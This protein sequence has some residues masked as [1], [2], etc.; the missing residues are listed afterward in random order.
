MTKEVE[1]QIITESGDIFHKQTNKKIL[2]VLE[3][4][5]MP[6]L[7]SYSVL[8]HAVFK[9]WTLS[10]KT[11][12]SGEYNFR[13]AVFVQTGSPEGSKASQAPAAGGGWQLCQ[14]P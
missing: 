5:A 11:A 8:L 2:S 9:L 13:V 10:Q 14:A 7:S 1:L 4:T 12:C 3:T 6:H